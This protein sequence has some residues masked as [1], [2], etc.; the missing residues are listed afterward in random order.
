LAVILMSASLANLELR[1]GRGQVTAFKGEETRSG[2]EISTKPHLFVVVKIFCLILGIL[3]PLAII[4]SLRVPEGRWRLFTFLCVILVIYLLVNYV[5]WG[6]SRV[7]LPGLKTPGSVAGRLPSSGEEYIPRPPRW[8]VF[9]ASFGVSTL[10]LG[11]S[12]IMW[13]RWRQRRTSPLDLVAQEAQKTIEEV[14]AGA[15]LKEGIIRCYFEMSRILKEQYGQSRKRAMTTREFERYLED[16]GL[17]GIHVKRLT[18]LFEK[19][20]YGAKVLSEEEEREAMDCLSS[21]ARTG[22]GSL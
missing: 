8:M 6:K 4:Y 19:A 11:V 20:R 5:P 17:A 13:R 2:G 18:L 12:L 21:I 3:T 14:H 9:M 16:A 22:E 7:G 15:N 10:I 1:P